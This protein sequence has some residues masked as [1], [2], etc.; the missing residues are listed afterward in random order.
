MPVSLQAAQATH[1]PEVGRVFQ[2][3]DHL[4]NIAHAGDEQVA[5]FAGVENA[6]GAHQHPAGD[7]KDIFVAVV[8]VGLRDVLLSG[9]E[10]DITP[11]LEII[12]GLV[13][14]FTLDNWH[15]EFDR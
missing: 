15:G 8:K 5:R 4:V 1:R 10:L 2:D 14:I 7:H 13:G 6:L 3:F 9:T 11:V 12:G